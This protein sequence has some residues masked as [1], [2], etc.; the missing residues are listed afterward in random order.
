MSNL[1]NLPGNLW[2][3][4]PPGGK[5]VPTEEYD[6]AKESVE[7]LSAIIDEQGPFMGIIVY[8]QGAAFIPVYLSNNLV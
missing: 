6:W 7:S 4:D 3:K 1:F 5:D 2:I 8:S